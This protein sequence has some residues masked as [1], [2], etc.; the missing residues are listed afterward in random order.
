M[1]TQNS[2]HL[3]TQWLVRE[4][5]SILSRSSSLVYTVDSTEITEEIYL[6]VV[7]LILYEDECIEG[8]SLLN[9]YTYMYLSTL[10]LVDC[11]I[12]FVRIQFLTSEGTRSHWAA[13]YESDGFELRVLNN[14]EKKASF[15]SP[16]ALK[17]Q[18]LL[19]RSF[20]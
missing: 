8:D 11:H 4:Y 2:W 1:I 12:G 3:P 14:G 10:H 20:G 16:Q 19:W 13:N 18:N 17:A 5:D 6:F 15:K 7:K 9:K